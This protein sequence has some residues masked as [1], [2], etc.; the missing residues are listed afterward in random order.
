MLQYM[1]G[2]VPGHKSAG[3]Q[4]GHREENVPHS[5]QGNHSLEDFM[6]NYKCTQIFVVPQDNIMWYYHRH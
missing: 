5:L 1:R 6:T 3:R 2:C 4:S